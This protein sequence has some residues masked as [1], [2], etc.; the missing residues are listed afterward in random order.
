[1]A[2]ASLG[3]ALKDSF[4]T[5]FVVC[6]GSVSGRFYSAKFSKKGPNKCIFVSGK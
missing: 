2:V 3:T 4:G 1:M 5:Y 6:C